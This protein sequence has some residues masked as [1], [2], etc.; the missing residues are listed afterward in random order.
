MAKLLA[1]DML[2]A[3][4]G[5]RGLTQ[6]ELADQTGISAA[7][8]S[9]ILNG[10]RGI[11]YGAAKRLCDVLK[12]RPLEV[13]NAQTEEA[14]LRRVQ[15]NGPPLYWNG[16]KVPPA[17]KTDVSRETVPGGEINADCP[18][19]SR[20]G[21][22]GHCQGCGYYRKVA[23]GSG[24]IDVGPPDNRRWSL[25]GTLLPGSGDGL[26]GTD[27]TIGRPTSVGVAVA[28]A[29]A[30]GA[31]TVVVY[32]QDPVSDQVAKINK[33]PP[34]PAAKAADAWVE[35]EAAPFEGEE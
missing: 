25:D 32:G 13:L 17:A 5:G 12:L 8:V 19:C 24:S 9:D 23:P 6:R 21:F 2:K 29:F 33:G 27:S 34:A 18:L 15:P 26:G 35:E 10:R 3:A 30:T 11:S 22:N 28:A 4:M 1:R 7:Y 31:K 16:D 20:A 14:Y